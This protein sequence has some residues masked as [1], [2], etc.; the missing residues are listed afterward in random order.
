[1]LEDDVYYSHWFLDYFCPGSGKNDQVEIISEITTV[2]IT[3]LILYN[4]PF[5]PYWC[6]SEHFSWFLWETILEYVPNSIIWLL[7]TTKKFLIKFRFKLEFFF[8]ICKRYIYGK[9]RRKKLKLKS[10]LKGWL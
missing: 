7:T 9:E 10:Q 6:R 1:M 2:V 4:P 5:I 8:K 3:V